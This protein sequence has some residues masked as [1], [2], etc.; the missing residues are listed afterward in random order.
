VPARVPEQA[1]VAAVAQPEGGGGLGCRSGRAG[2]A[3]LDVAQ[4]AAH[5]HGRPFGDSEVGHRAGR[6]RRHLDRDL[7]GLELAQGLVDRDGVA[8]LDQPLGDGRLGDRFAQRRNL[9]LEGH[10]LLLSPA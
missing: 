8:R 5:L 2:A 1:S 9:D 6:G 4:H 10:A 3:R 7:V